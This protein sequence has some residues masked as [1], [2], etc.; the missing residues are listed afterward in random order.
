MDKL[1]LRVNILLPVELEYTKESLK[2]QKKL[3]LCLLNTH[4]A[5]VDTLNKS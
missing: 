2:C 5:S 3:L 4:N 1:A